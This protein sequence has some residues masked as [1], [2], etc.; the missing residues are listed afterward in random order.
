MIDK[1][2]RNIAIG[3]IGCGYW[4]PKLVR[5]FQSIPGSDL[6]MVADFRQDRLDHI[7]GLY[8]GVKTTSDHR[9]L[10]DSPV[11]AVAIATPVLSHF[12]LA[13]EALLH[14]KHVL[15]EKPLTTSSAEARELIDLAEEH[16]RVL[17]VG[18]TFEYNPAVEYLR[19]F[20]A[21]GD[22]GRVYYI[23]ATRV[24]LG[25]FQTDINVIWDLG[26]HD[27]AILLY[28]FGMKPNQVSA[29]GAA[30]VQLR[31]EDVAH[32]T[33]SFP[34]GIMADVRVSW[35]DPCKIRRITVVGSKKMIVYD[36]VEPT[37]KIRIYDKGVD[38]PPYSDTMEE[39]RL[40]YRYGDITTPAISNAEPLALECSHFLECIRH[41]QVPRS[42]GEVGL[43]VVRILEGAQRS[44]K[45][46]GYPEDLSW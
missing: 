12:R 43:Q 19:N 28:I 13:R 10:L 17:M 37:E 15:V 46:G 29:R 4:G 16:Q 30:Y 42:D 25:I 38:A 24:N 31:I 32:V 2:V 3:V 14:D 34:G 45:N 9:E 41:D 6:R 7:R 5:N 39:F 11:E 8:P 18:H 40:S 35:L 36:D 27:V 23:D 21:A 22:L 1:E 26:P 33:L 44:L 20:I